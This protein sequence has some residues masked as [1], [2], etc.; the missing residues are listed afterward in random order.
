MAATAVDR[1]HDASFAQRL[2]GPAVPRTR[3]WT[4]GVALRVE[5]RPRNASITPSW[6]EARHVLA[7]GSAVEAGAERVA[8]RALHAPVVLFAANDFSTP[9]AGAIFGSARRRN[10]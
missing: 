1:D 10:W 7:L 5:G 4:T 8:R 9:T 6:I 3:R 2:T